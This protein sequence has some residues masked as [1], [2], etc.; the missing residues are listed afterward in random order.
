MTESASERFLALAAPEQRQRVKDWLRQA[1]S[2]ED[3]RDAFLTMMDGYGAHLC[4]QPED[5]NI[6]SHEAGG[7]WRPIFPQL[8]ARPQSAF[9][10]KMARVMRARRDYAKAAFFHGFPDEAEVHHEIET[11]I[12]FQLPLLAGRLPGHEAALESILDVAEHVGNWVYS[13]PPWYDWETQRFVSTFLGTRSTRAHPPFDYQEA[14]HWRFVAVALAAYRATEDQRYLDLAAGYAETWCT[15]I[16]GTPAGDPVRCSVLPPGIEAREMSRSGIQDDGA[17]GYEIF[18]S[19]VALNTAYDIFCGLVDVYRLTGNKRCLEAARRMLDQFY[20]RAIDGRPMSRYR[21]GKWHSTFSPDAADAAGG[22][23]QAGC[24]LSRMALRHDVLTG[25][26]RYEKAIT[27]WAAAID[28]ERWG[29]DQMMADPLLAAWWYTGN[30]E[31][32]SRAF[33]MALRL[34]A[35][36]EADD[37]YHMCNCRNRYGS[38]FLMELHYLPVTGRIDAGTRGGLGVVVTLGE[39]GG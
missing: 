24:F 39:R 7:A 30:S 25:E 21:D 23:T 2:W 14:N 9:T 32:L 37:Q 15:H 19:T 29:S 18:Y 36:A 1:R 4:E 13:V 12:Y 11:F 5:R 28:E 22:V 27:T 16:E 8:E 33:A 38:K 26:R 31:Y 17:T 3:L 20:D 6:A 35:F 34:W 10:D